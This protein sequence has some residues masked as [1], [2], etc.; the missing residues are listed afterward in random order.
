M[1]AS[2]EYQQRTAALAGRDMFSHDRVLSVSDFIDS[3][4]AVALV[5]KWRYEDGYKPCGPKQQVSDHAVLV[6]FQLL[7]SEYNAFSINEAAKAVM[8]RLS[9]ESL[10]H[11][12]LTT[13][14]SLLGWE[15]RFRRALE[16]VT[17]T[18]D[19]YIGHNHRRL[20]IAEAEAE[21]Q[22]RKA[23]PL[24]AV[25]QKRID[26]F[27]DCLTFG[28]LN[29]VIPQDVQARYRGN[30]TIDGTSLPV[31]T[32]WKGPQ[33]KKD[34]AAVDVSAGWWGRQ[35][36]HRHDG[37]EAPEDEG[38]GRS[39]KG[40]FGYEADLLM[41]STNDPTKAAEFPLVCPVV[42]LK[43]PGHKTGELALDMVQS[44]ARHGY[45]TKTLISDMAIAPGSKVEKLQGPL[46]EM[47]RSLH[48][49]RQ[50]PHRTT[51]QRPRGAHLGRWE[52]LLRGHARRTHL[53]HEGPPRR[54]HLAGH[55]LPSPRRAKA[56]P[57][58]GERQAQRQWCRPVH[59]PDGTRPPRVQP[60]AQGSPEVL[61]AAD[62]ARPEVET[63][64]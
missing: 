4:G 39:G 61:Q 8:A 9:P 54:T 38:E 11:L 2:N 21:Y 59:P 18:F 32:K 30:F 45:P 20:T 51:Q 34:S 22:R 1:S 63:R 43:R 64:P 14:A 10:R 13:T 12:G 46:F 57:R 42:R 15:Q 36:N 52:P 3:T 5:E 47:S 37:M 17:D 40:K 7:V 48:P 16:R 33:P 58:Q 27:S 53:G 49:H 35:G 29:W 19:P 55:A 24:H 44:M 62:R 56:V 50:D 31:V 23:D 26:E 28:H 60:G 25:K 41:W 6:V